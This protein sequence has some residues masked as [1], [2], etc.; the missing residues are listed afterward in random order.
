MQQNPTPGNN[1]QN[2]T[3]NFVDLEAAMK[4]LRDGI[5]DVYSGLKQETISLE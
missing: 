1:P 5:S 3:N 2:P 4:K